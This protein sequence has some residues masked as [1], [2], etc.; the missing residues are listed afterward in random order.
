VSVRTAHAGRPASYTLTHDH[1]APASFGARS[2][3]AS[4]TART[5]APHPLED[6]DRLAW[7]ATAS[8]SLL[9]RFGDLVVVALD[10]VGRGDD[11]ALLSA[12]TERELLMQQLQPLLGALSG[13]RQYMAAAPPHTAAARVVDEILAPVD[14]ALRHAQLLHSRLSGEVRERGWE[15]AASSAALAR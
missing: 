6:S 10:A 9:E 15:S 11:A 5:A 3:I 7:Q 2:A 8:V 1:A 13:A 12:L 4:I 14:D